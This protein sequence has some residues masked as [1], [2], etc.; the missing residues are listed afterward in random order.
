[1][2]V[3]VYKIG[4]NVI[5]SP[6]ALDAFCRAVAAVPGKKVI[7]HGGG[8]MASSLQEKLGQKVVKVEGRR[9]TDEDALKA[10]TMVYAG[11][12]NKSIVARLQSLGVNALGLSGCDG[13]VVLAGRRAPRTLS[14]GR[15]V[16][17]YGFVGD[18]VKESVNAAFLSALMDMGCVPVLCAI[19]HD[20]KGQLLNTNADTVAAS[21]AASLCAELVCCFEMDG[22]LR[23]IDDRS[24]VIRC[25]RARE[26][27]TLVSGG[28][29]SGGMM[30][31]VEN[32][33]KALR[34]GA[35]KAVITN[36]DLSS[37]GTEILL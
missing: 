13:N 31:K 18:V 24:S 16:L 15:T 35:A 36:S 14:D 12:C 33:I 20:G 26:F 11:W 23:D 32:C 25:I 28:V 37:E 4:G 19:N 8:V 5:E 22:V 9:V 30:P 10:V 17:D 1:M 6:D 3:R 21:V 2:M 34:E 27:G 29:I 7:V